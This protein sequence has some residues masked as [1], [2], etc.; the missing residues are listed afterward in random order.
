MRGRLLAGK[1][2][3]KH[4]GKNHHEGIIWA[5]S[6][7][8]PFLNKNYSTEPT[9]T[10]FKRCNATLLCRRKSSREIAKVT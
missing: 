2:G 5:E 8:K 10:F 6:K 7:I 9:L 4:L 3:D 1:V